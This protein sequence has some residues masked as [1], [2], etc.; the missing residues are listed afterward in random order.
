MLVTVV[1][2]FVVNLVSAMPVPP[3]L[4]HWA[5]DGTVAVLFVV[6]LLTIYGFRTAQRRALISG[7]ALTQR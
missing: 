6:S 3:S 1:A 2:I 5:A 7:G 4:G